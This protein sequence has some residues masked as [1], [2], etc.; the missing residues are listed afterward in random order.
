MLLCGVNGI[1][2]DSVGPE[3]GKIF[4]V[5]LAGGGVG[6]GINVYFVI[7]RLGGVAAE[8]TSAGWLY[9]ERRT[10]RGQ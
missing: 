8:F 2:T 9:C 4:D 3:F 1:D 10:A 5:A 6:K 7:G